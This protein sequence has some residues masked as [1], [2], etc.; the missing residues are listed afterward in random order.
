MITEHTVSP[1]DRGI[2]LAGSIFDEPINNV[3][4]T[5]EQRDAQ[6]LTETVMIDGAAKTFRRPYPSPADWRDCW[7]YFVMI[8]RFNNPDLPPAS[9]RTYPPSAWDSIYCVRQGGTLKGIREG[10]AYVQDLGANAICLSPVMKNSRSQTWEGEYHGYGAQD[11]LRI[12]PRFASDGTAATAEIELTELVNEAHAR[13]VYVCLDIVLNHAGRVFDYVYDGSVTDYFEDSTLMGAPLGEEP[14]IR[15]L[16]ENGRPREDWQ[17]SFPPG[18]SLSDNDAVWPQDLQ[19][20]DFFRRRGAKLTDDPTSGGFVHGDFGRMRQLVVEYRAGPDLQPDLYSRYGPYPVLTILLRIYQYM[21]AKFDFD[22]FR[23]DSAKYV[24]PWAVEWFRYHI[25]EFTSRIGKKNFLIFTEVY[26]DER[27]IAAFVSPMACTNGLRSAYAAL[28][29]PLFY[30]LPSIAKG[31]DSVGVETLRHLFGERHAVENRDLDPSNAP[32]RFFVTFLDNHDQK[33]RF[34]HS[35]ASV[36]QVVLGL[37][38]LFCLP[39][40]PCL[41][42]GTEQ[43]LQGTRDEKGRL[44]LWAFESVREALWGK[45]AAFDRKSFLFVTIGRLS[46]L[47]SGEIALRRGEIYF[48]E[49]SGNGT[50]FGYSSGAGGIVAFSR[51]S[52]EREVLVVANTHPSSRFTGFVIADPHLTGCNDGIGI[53]YSTVGTSGTRTVS[54]HPTARFCTDGD[55]PGIGR[56]ACV[57]VDLAPKELQV[58]AH[59]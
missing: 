10:L 29:F 39:G 55:Q 12:E 33:Q 18:L 24:A 23:F 48:R 58:L 31:V 7:I 35:D 46:K 19:R 11:F 45:P 14:L 51:I 25:S 38:L 42:Y 3:I 22:G 20:P 54:V 17:N 32:G 52:G 15:W 50:D 43:S 1:H 2:A 34:N 30:K 36:G 41:Y 47:R 6:G 40:I 56:A 49:V 53:L 16:D 28:D 37:A 27:T 21:I 26:G 59:P 13:G 5:V 57:S 44:T 4:T 9:T 8:D